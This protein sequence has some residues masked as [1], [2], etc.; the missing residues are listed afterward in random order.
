M[1]GLLVKVRDTRLDHA[2]LL[3]VDGRTL[4]RSKP[5]R[6]RYLSALL[7]AGPTAFAQ[8]W[9]RNV[10]LLHQDSVVVRR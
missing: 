7:A 1:P 4:L 2:G 5:R 8:Y 9:W 3:R 6:E 10:V